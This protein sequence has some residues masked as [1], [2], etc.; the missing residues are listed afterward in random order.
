MSFNYYELTD[1]EEV[2]KTKLMT[3]EVAEGEND[4]AR[5]LTDGNIYWRKVS[6]NE[7]KA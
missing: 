4:L 3:K 5:I 6:D 7:N 2:F 1:G